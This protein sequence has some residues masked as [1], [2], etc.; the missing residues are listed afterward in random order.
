MIFAKLIAICVLLGPV[1]GQVGG[2]G[3]R[4]ASFDDFPHQVRI[5]MI[6][7]GINEDEFKGTGTLLRDVVEGEEHTFVLTAAH[8]F[9]PLTIRGHGSYN[10]E[11]V[12]IHYK[13][14][15]EA[16]WTTE[17]VHAWR[18]HGS[19]NHGQR[20]CIDDHD[21][22]LMVLKKPVEDS[23]RSATLPYPDAE[24][25]FFQQMRFAGFGRTHL[26][27]ASDKTLNEGRTTLLP[28]L[29]CREIYNTGVS[30]NLKSVLSNLQ[31]KLDETPEKDFRIFERINPALICTGAKKMKGQKGSVT[32][33]GLPGDSGCGLFR[34]QS[35]LDSDVVYGVYSS[36]CSSKYTGEFGQFVNPDGWVRVS[37]KIPWILSKIKELGKSLASENEKGN[38]CQL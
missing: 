28:F 22:A 24:M 36:G 2:P 9:K 10:V 4:D 32:S 23:V 27:V 6:Y 21:I 13:A 38:N 14:S 29:Y 17:K 33:F 18:I 7:K 15:A 37:E 11:S 19:Y 35:E 25:E 8:L 3:R 16:G 26:N 34:L 20:S 5:H 31:R 30:R 12:V 1:S